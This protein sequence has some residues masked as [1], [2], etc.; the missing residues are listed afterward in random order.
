MVR[1]LNNSCLHEVKG[2]SNQV[3]TFLND[4]DNESQLLPPI[5]SACESITDASQWTVVQDLI[6]AEAKAPS[7]SKIKCNISTGAPCVIIE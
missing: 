6:I 3:Y 2:Y 1:T 5:I 4:E 7:T